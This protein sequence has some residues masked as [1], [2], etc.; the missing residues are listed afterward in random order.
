MGKLAGMGRIFYGTAITGMGVQTIYYHDLPYML[1]APA[2]FPTSVLLILAYVFGVL[3]ILA[4]L[5]IILKIKI[6]PV[7]L[8]LGTMLLLIFCLYYI[9][10]QLMENPNYL[11]LIEWDNAEKEWALSS[12]AFIIA[13][14]FPEKRENTFFSYLAKGI[15]LGTI[16]FA[17]AILSFGI[18]H[19]LYAKGVAEYIPLWV[20]NKIFWAYC[21]GVGLFGSALGI[22]LKFRT[23]TMAILLGSMIFIWFIILHIPKVIGSLKAD[24]GGEI[25]SAFLALAYSGIA[26][27]VAGVAQNKKLS[28]A[29]Q[30][31]PVK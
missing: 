24:P 9:P 12:G 14:C 29:D 16:F 21:A 28:Q 2:N 15:P 4:G 1:M 25:T 31:V 23:Q 11:H 20:P 10:Y 22:I 6:R 19:F 17:I 18:D 8:L 30:P 27:V 7:C 5:S 3:F 26:F 13:G